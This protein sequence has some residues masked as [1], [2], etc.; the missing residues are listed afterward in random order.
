[1]DMERVIVAAKQR[2]CVLE[3]NGHPDR[4]DL[5]DIN[6]KMAKEAGMRIAISTDAHSKTDLALM[7]FGIAQARR[8]WLEPEDVI[9]TGSLPD[10]K[11]ALNRA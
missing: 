9:N 5:A 10:L 3:L 4:L 1:M 8:G 7:R 11:R 2:G 6:C